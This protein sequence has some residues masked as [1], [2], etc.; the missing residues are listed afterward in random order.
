MA[1]LLK[2]M[3]DISGRSVMT[4]RGVFLGKAAD[5]TID[6]ETGTIHRLILKNGMFDDLLRGKHELPIEDITVFGADVIL[7]AEGIVPRPE[8]VGRK[9]PPKNAIGTA[10]AS[11]PQSTIKQKFLHSKE[12]AVL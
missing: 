9:A 3:P 6:S 7:T 11:T 1:S 2:A 8:A 4:E 10:T 12:P 5:F